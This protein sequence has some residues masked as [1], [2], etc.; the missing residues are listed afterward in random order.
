MARWALVLCSAAMGVALI[1]GTSWGESCPVATNP[2]SG[3][4]IMSGGYVTF[5]CDKDL[6]DPIC[7]AWWGSDYDYCW[8]AWYT[9][10]LDK[11]HVP[12]QTYAC[13]STRGEGCCSGGTTPPSSCSPGD[14]NTY[15]S[16]Q[17]CLEAN[18]MNIP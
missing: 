7:C 16:H 6:G 14:Y 12:I 4:P 11:K 15:T 2:V 13:S 1:L 9:A 18:W 10:Y 8:L 3:I 17:G 5:C